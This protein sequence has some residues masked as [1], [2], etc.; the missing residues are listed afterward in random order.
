MCF[1]SW[2]KLLYTDASAV[3]KVGGA[4]SVK[5][6]VRRGIRQ[7]CPLSVWKM[8][9]EVSRDIRGSTEWILEEPLLYNPLIQTRLLSSAG[10]RACLLRKGCT[11]LGHCMDVN[12]WK[13]PIELGEVTGLQ[14]C[15]VVARLLEEVKS[16]LPRC[17]QEEG[18]RDS[19]QEHFLFLAW[20]AEVS[21]GVKYRTSKRRKMCLLNDVGTV[22]R[23]VWKT[24]KNKARGAG[25]ASPELRVKWLM[26]GRIR[27][28][29]EYCRR[30]E[31]VEVLVDVWGQSDVLIATLT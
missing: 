28:E 19:K 23:A 8:V 9:F 2:L 30:V 29:H 13:S 20:S 26:A 12:G 22:K 7:D 1:V 16:A 4:L 18:C 25:C 17:W 5:A 27:V 3:V 10:V 21:A 14:S 6:P 31:Q 24:R 15:R 11:K